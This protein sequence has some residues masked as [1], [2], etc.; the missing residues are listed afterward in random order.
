MRTTIAELA[1]RTIS[2]IHKDAQFIIVIIITIITAIG[3]IRRTDNPLIIT[4]R[5]S[6]R[7]TKKIIA[8]QLRRTDG[9]DYSERW[10]VHIQPATGKNGR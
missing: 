9:A 5:I 7:P 2:S 8:S 6:P 1:H 3:V 4:V 10:A